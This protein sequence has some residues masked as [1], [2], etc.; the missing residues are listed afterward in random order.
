VDR[1]RGQQGVMDVSHVRAPP[2]GRDIDPDLHQPVDA[3]RGRRDDLFGRVAA[4]D[5]E[6]RVT[7]EYGRR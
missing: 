3:D 5:I 4:H 6:V 1:D 7:V 2:R